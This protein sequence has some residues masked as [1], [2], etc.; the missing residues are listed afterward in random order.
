MQETQTFLPN[1]LFLTNSFI[2]LFK[3]SVCAIATLNINLF[4]IH[5]KA[6]IKYP[7]D[8]W[9]SGMRASALTHKRNSQH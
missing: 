7:S 4:E 9:S 1:T 5:E 3:K 2:T 6:S 8:K